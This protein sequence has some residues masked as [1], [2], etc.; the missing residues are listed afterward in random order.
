MGSLSAEEISAIGFGCKGKKSNW[1]GVFLLCILKL[2]VRFLIENV[3]CS[4]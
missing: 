1:C 2:H 3:L 4:A